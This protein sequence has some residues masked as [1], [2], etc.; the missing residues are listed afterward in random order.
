ML[1]DVRLYEVF[2]QITL[3]SSF[4]LHSSLKP[5]LYKNSWRT[6]QSNSSE[7]QIPK[8]LLVSTDQDR[9]RAF[10]GEPDIRVIHSSI[11]TLSLLRHRLLHS[12][13]W[14]KIRHCSTAWSSDVVVGQGGVAD[15]SNRR[16]A[17]VERKQPAE[18]W[19]WTH[20]NCVSVTVSEQEGLKTRIPPRPKTSRRSASLGLRVCGGWWDCGEDREDEEFLSLIINL[21]FICS[22]GVSS[23]MMETSWGK[24]R[25]CYVKT[26]KPRP[27]HPFTHQWGQS[28]HASR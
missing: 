25:L 7:L 8:E 5:F 2:W 17:V 18:N 23:V 20:R 4:F 12:S 16:R 19:T 1:T 3:E 13:L 14:L 6:N 27:V 15:S 10:P 9:R 22:M 28:Y 21:F 11:N 24:T 26:L